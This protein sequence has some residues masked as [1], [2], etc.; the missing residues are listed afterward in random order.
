M[1]YARGRPGNPTKY[2]GD[3]PQWAGNPRSMRA[4]LSVGQAPVSWKR[5]RRLACWGP[6]RRGIGESWMLVRAPLQ[7]PEVG[8]GAARRMRKRA[9]SPRPGP[10]WRTGEPLSPPAQPRAELPDHCIAEWGPPEAT[11]LSFIAH[12]QP[13]PARHQRESPGGSPPGELG[14]P[15][16][17]HGGTIGAVAPPK[18]ETEPR[19]SREIE[20]STGH[21]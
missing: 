17:R 19:P 9:E 15:R 12:H 10:P 5:G 13:D 1:G 7:P 18:S 21:S 6:E 4:L 11:R 20:V 14:E 3:N 2:A 16:A 8:A